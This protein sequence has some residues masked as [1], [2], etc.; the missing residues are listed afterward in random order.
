MTSN[1]AVQRQRFSAAQKMPSRFCAVLVG[2]HECGHGGQNIHGE[3]HG[4]A[5]YLCCV[6]G[7]YVVCVL[8]V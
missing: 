7:P 3:R 2:G 6:G 5:F 4:P 1:V 8:T